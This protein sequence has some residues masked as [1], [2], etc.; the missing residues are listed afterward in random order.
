MCLGQTRASAGEIEEA[1]LP[2]RGGGLGLQRGVNIDP[3]ENWLNGREKGLK[4]AEGVLTGEEKR[5]LFCL[6]GAVN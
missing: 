4:R 5:A 2:L 6:G 3:C 1:L